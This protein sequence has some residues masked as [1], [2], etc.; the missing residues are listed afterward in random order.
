MSGLVLYTTAL[1]KFPNIWFFQ[2]LPSEVRPQ[3]SPR[4]QRIGLGIRYLYF[5]LHL[6][7]EPLSRWHPQGQVKVT[8]MFSYGTSIGIFVVSI[9]S[10]AASQLI[11]KWRFGV[12]FPEGGATR[13]ATGHV[14]TAASDAWVL[15]GVGLIVIGG[16][17]WYL[18]MSRL[19]LTFMMP[20][21]ASIAPITVVC[22]YFFLKEPLTLGQIAAIAM[23]AAGVAWLGYQR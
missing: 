6:S 10:V 13:S 12:L 7:V 2:G 22:A 20:V 9:L 5:T 16:S 15:A 21:A 19:P 14:M 8:S 4:C 1:S 23:I 18:A 17:S 11:M 3:S